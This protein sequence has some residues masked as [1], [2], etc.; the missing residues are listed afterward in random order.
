MT[1]GTCYNGSNN[2]YSNFNSLMSDSRIFTD[3]STEYTIENKLRNEMKIGN[4]TN[5]RH[6]LQNNSD[7]II[8][9]NQL[10]SCNSC[11]YCQYKDNTE[12]PEKDYIF[13]ENLLKNV[14]FGY[15]NSDLKNVY[16]SREKMNLE[17]NLPSFYIEDSGEI[18]K[19]K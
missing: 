4:N 13:R 17:L 16:L 14:N 8:S 1:W 15:N 3:Y 7:K 2:I 9:N 5:Y 11:S 6:Y 10:K 12:L 18:I 19:K